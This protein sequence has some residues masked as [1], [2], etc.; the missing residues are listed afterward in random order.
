MYGVSQPGISLNLGQG[1]CFVFCAAYLGNTFYRL[2][3]QD[4]FPSIKQSLKL[5]KLSSVCKGQGFITDR[6]GKLKLQQVKPGLP[7]RPCR[8]RG[9]HVSSD[10]ED[11]D[12]EDSA[13]PPAHKPCGMEGWIVVLLETAIR[14]VGWVPRTIYQFMG[15][16]TTFGMFFIS[17]AMWMLIN[18]T[19]EIFHT[20]I[21]EGIQQMSIAQ[22]F[23]RV[24]LDSDP[25]VM[26][27]SHRVFM[28]HALPQSKT[29]YTDTSFEVHFR[30][31]HAE[32]TCLYELERTLWSDLN[33]VLRVTLSHAGS[34]SL[35]GNLFEGAVHK[36][37][38]RLPSLKLIRMVSMAKKKILPSKKNGKKKGLRTPSQ[39]QFETFHLSEM[40]DEV[41]FKRLEVENF[42]F[43]APEHINLDLYYRGCRTTALIDGFLLGKRKGKIDV[44]FLQIT[45]SEK[46]DSHSLKRG[47]Q[48]IANI[49]EKIRSSFKLPVNLHFVLVGPSEEVAGEKEPKW[50][51]PN[52]ET[53]GFSY[54]VYYCKL[55]LS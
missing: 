31:I 3:V 34:R 5:L 27:I 44:Y 12:D 16:P 2:E 18:L 40:Q 25:D 23:L 28:Q 54:D 26:A 43:D 15:R 29:D 32:F 7:P 37:I 19:G 55:R 42:T 51:L 48:L 6:N 11:F 35:A 10:D 30:T 14:Q 20:C 38:P 39:G 50:R 52:A 8:P 9:D 4:T 1:K 36:N 41:D 33:E 24:A 47:P 45:T 49:I 17:G 53:L 22:H 21:R 13:T 46:K